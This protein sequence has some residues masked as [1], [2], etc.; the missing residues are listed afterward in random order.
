MDWCTVNSRRSKICAENI[1]KYC[2]VGTQARSHTNTN[3]SS[4]LRFLV[5]IRADGYWTQEKDGA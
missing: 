1:G 2:E 4:V 3:D 5:L